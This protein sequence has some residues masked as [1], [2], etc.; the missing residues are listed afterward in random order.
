[1]PDAVAS[2][3]LTEPKFGGRLKPPRPDA[4][5]PKEMRKS[6]TV[7]PSRPPSPRAAP[8]AAVNR[9]A[10]STPAVKLTAKKKSSGKPFISN[11]GKI[12][13]PSVTFGPRASSQSLNRAPRARVPVP[14][15]PAAI[16]TTPPISP[17]PKVAKASVPPPP[18][19]VKRVTP[20]APKQTAAVPRVPPPP[21]PIAASVH[22]ASYRS[23]AAAKQGWTAL[24][25]ANGDLLRGLEPEIRQVAVKGKGVFFR[26]YAGPVR[27]SSATELC[28]KL[29]DRGVFCS[30]RN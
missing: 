24:K 27:S 22:L 9:A 19:I 16:S 21:A 23:A 7:K 15:P 2:L 26:L 5:P 14:P 29:N 12:A 4:S 11:A 18:P 6:A 8:V 1:M 25:S 20:K 3:T 28:R 10:V 13:P 17:K 30:P